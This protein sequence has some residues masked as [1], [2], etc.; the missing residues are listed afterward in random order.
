MR[1][2]VKEVTGSRSFLKGTLNERIAILNPIIQGWR[3]YYAAI[4]PGVANRFLSKIDWYIRKRLIL[5]WN[6]KHKRRKAQH[7]QLHQMLNVIGLKTVSSWGVRTA[8][9]EE[10]RKAVC[11]KTARTV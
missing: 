7:A 5:F 10:R 1:A 2:R 11:G 8:H 4:D 3:N 9:G 6:K